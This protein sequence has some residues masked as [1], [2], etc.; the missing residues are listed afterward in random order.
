MMEHV[1]QNEL[2]KPVDLSELSALHDTYM[3]ELE[4]EEQLAAEYEKTKK[5]P[6][7]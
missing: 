2:N 4:Q 6:E 7:D 1:Q 5:L 3:Q